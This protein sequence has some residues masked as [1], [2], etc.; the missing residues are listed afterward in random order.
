M[1]IVKLKRHLR[2][3]GNVN[4]ESVRPEP[5]YA[6]HNYLKN[7]NKFY[8]DISI[9]YGLSSNGI[10]N[11]TDASFAHEQTC[12]NHPHT[13]TE[14]KLNFELFDDPLNLYR[15]APNEIALISEI[16]GIIDEDNI[17]VAPGQGK[18][19]LSILRDDYCEEKLDIR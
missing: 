14:N 4:F 10:S 19:P 11:V 2:Y 9:S 15:V 5:I 13:K 8:E 17:T 1:I 16:P 7:K 12:N 18:S 3:R 6:H